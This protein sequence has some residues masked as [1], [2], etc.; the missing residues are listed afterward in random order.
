MDKDWNTR[1]EVGRPFRIQ[2]GTVKMFAIVLVLLLAA[3]MVFGY[4]GHGP[5][6]WIWFLIEC[7][8]HGCNF[9]V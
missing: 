7:Y 3:G 1:F 4:Y 9:D 6:K 8:R 2:R 5:L